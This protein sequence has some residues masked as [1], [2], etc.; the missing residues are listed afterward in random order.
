MCINGQCQKICQ[1]NG[2]TP[3]ASCQKAVFT[4]L[5]LSNHE[6]SES[7]VSAAVEIDVKPIFNFDSHVRSINSYRLCA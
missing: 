2:V 7:V 4:T 1:R 6:T 5:T 3:P